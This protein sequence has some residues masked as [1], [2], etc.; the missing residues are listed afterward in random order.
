MKKKEQTQ[1]EAIVDLI[2]AVSVMA[3]EMEKLHKRINK[4]E[5]KK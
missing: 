4:L 1:K 5:K 2:V 3:E